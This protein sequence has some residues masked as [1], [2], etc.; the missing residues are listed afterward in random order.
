MVSKSFKHRDVLAINDFSKE[1]ILHVLDQTALMKASPPKD[2][3]NNKIMA[4]CFFEPSTRTRLS[5][6]SAMHRL[7]GKVIG[8][9][10][11][12]Q[13][14]TSK[15]ESLYDSMKMLEG[16][17]DVVVLRHPLE[18][19][20]KEAADAINIPVINAGDGANQH[21]TQTFLDL[22][23]IKESQGTLDNLHIA[24]V[25]DLKYGRTVHSL[26]EALLHFNCRL[27]FVSSPSLEI[28]SAFCE[29][30]RTNGIKFSFHRDL[31]EIL[32]KLDIVYMTRLQEERFKHRG[33][34]EEVIAAYR[35]T[36]DKLKNCKPNLRVF[37]PLPRVDEIDRSV[38][39]T[40]HAYYFSQAQNGLYTRQAL[41]GLLLDAK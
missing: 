22:F 5:F 21:P 35:L 6:E 26:T 37:H 14:S 1:E 34:F 23:S 41:L 24:L 32:P 3:L 12:A 15:G 17:A 29:L 13:T 30:F 36:A 9:S 20:A 38:D 25:G 39:D 19:S 4:S 40:P 33:E 27:Y 8:F 11:S 2:L 28:P 18:G 10:S 7:G 16:Y 31:A